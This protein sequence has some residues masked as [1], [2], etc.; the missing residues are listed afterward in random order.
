[1][2]MSLRFKILKRNSAK[3]RVKTV[4]NSCFSQCFSASMSCSGGGGKGGIP[5]YSDRVELPDL[6][7]CWLPVP[8]GLSCIE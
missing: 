8:K 1:M 7:T 4:G 3:G 2:K 6:G 5:G